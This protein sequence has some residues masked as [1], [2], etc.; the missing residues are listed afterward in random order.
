MHCSGCQQVKRSCGWGLAELSF[1]FS[2]LTDLAVLSATGPNPSLVVQSVL[3][4]CPAD[5][6]TGVSHLSFSEAHRLPDTMNGIH[7]PSE[8]LAGASESVLAKITQL[9]AGAGPGS[10][11]LKHIADD[12]GLH[13]EVRK[14]RKKIRC[15]LKG[16]SSLDTRRD[17]TTAMQLVLACACAVLDATAWTAANMWVLKPV[18]CDDCW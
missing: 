1:R 6:C 5:L 3:F 11:G 2:Y 17:Q 14:P 12:L 9:Y 4:C 10:L 13:R 15:V 7:P 18:Q 8:A 16:P